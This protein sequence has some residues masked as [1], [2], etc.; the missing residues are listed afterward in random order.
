MFTAAAATSKLKFIRLFLF[1]KHEQVKWQ[2]LRANALN[3]LGSRP[4]N[5]FSIWS[6]LVSRYLSDHLLLQGW[7]HFLFGGQKNFPQKICGHKNKS[8]KP[9]W[10]KYNLEKKM[11]VKVGEN[12]SYS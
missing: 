6:P 3:K 11:F 12:G 9:W 2:P 1:C 8:L 7:P 5:F 4:H 10:A